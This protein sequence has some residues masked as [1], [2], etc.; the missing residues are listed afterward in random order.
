[1]AGVC[2]ELRN[3]RNLEV[4]ESE[5]KCQTGHL[6]H[7]Y[8]EPRPSLP[9]WFPFGT[10]EVVSEATRLPF[11]PWPRSPRGVMCCDRMF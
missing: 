8:C 10:W 3:V 5:G 6:G 7:T 1:M 2:P 11:K 4:V 9:S